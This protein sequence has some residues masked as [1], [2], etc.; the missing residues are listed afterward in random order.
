MRRRQFITLLGSAAAW[1]MT[2]RAQQIE[3]MRRA[4][5]TLRPS[6]ARTLI[7]C[8]CTRSSWPF[9]SAIYLGVAGGAPLPPWPVELVADAA[10]G[11]WAGRGGSLDGVDEASDEG[12]QRHERDDHA[13]TANRKLLSCPAVNTA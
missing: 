9:C 8:R 2:T 3:G 12:G 4:R 5:A 13:S 10:G 1:P 6:E 11:R 7:A